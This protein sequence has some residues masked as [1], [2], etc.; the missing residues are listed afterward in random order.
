MRPIRAR[1]RSAAA[2]MRLRGRT[3]IVLLLAATLTVAC[4]PTGERR[5]VSIREGELQPGY[6]TGELLYAETRGVRQSALFIHDLWE[7]TRERLPLP[8]GY[9]TSPNWSPDGQRIA[10]AFG[11]EDGR[12]HIWV[13]DRDGENLTRITDGEVVDDYPRWSPD[14]DSLVFA[15]IRDGDYD[16]RLFVVPVDRGREPRVVGSTDGHSVFP[17]WSN[18][19]RFIVYSNR[20]GDA[21]E[22]RVLDLVADVDRALTEGGEGGQHL[23]AQFSSDGREILFATD[24]DDDVWQIW[25]LDLATN[26]QE[27]VIGSDSM[28]E[29]PT[30]SP[31]DEFI[32]FSTGHLAVYRTDGGAF[33]DGQLRWAVT[34]NLAWAPDWR[35]AE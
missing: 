27:R 1:H 18:D 4:E 24:R 28:D 29:Y 5:L 23:Y 32:A 16:W 19:G 3:L 7:A 33:P 34:Q 6:L 8:R 17:D 22:L 11:T 20:D 21:Y 31:D 15:S 2:A 10:F 12:S 14:G 25:T 26:T 35:A 9:A 30:Y 13:V